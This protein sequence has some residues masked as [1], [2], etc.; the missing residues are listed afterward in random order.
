MGNS[1]DSRDDSWPSISGARFDAPELTAEVNRLA[2]NAERG[3]RTGC[4][5]RAYRRR[6]I[7]LSEAALNVVC[8]SS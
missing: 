6:L 3:P 4:G 8:L 2:R 7:P 1:L 5:E